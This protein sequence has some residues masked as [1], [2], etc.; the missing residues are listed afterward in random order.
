MK[1]VKKNNET[2][3]RNMDS[4]TVF[5]YVHCPSIF[6]LKAFDCDDDGD[7]QVNLSSGELSC[8]EED[9][10]VVIVEGSFI[11]GE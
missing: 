7:Y 5:Y 4:G 3:F 1:I 9:E 10:P 11:E 6:Y 2:F 8:P